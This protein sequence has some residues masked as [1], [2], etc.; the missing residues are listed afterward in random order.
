VANTGVD[1]YGKEEEFLKN[2]NVL[3]TFSNWER[4]S[5]TEIGPILLFLKSEPR[6][7]RTLNPQ[8]LCKM[9]GRSINDLE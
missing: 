3:V 6:R 8:V 2:G 1:N 5:P 9:V 7:S 4:K